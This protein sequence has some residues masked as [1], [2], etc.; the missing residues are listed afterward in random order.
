L[1]QNA[2]LSTILIF[3]RARKYSVILDEG[4]IVDVIL[5]LKPFH[6]LVK[7]F[8]QPLTLASIYI[9]GWILIQRFSRLA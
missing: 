3:K 8:K 9:Y 2:L 4:P 1:I 5:S 7:I 6:H